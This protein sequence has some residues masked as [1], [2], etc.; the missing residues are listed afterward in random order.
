M[1]CGKCGRKNVEEAT[2]CI[3]C[4]TRL[5]QFMPGGESKTV[6]RTEEPTAT[7][8]AYDDLFEKPAQAPASVAVPLTET[9]AQQALRRHAGS[10]LMTIVG[11][12]T[13]IMTVLSFFSAIASVRVWLPDFFGYSSATPAFFTVG[14]VFGLL[15]GMAPAILV[16]LAIWMLRSAARGGSTPMSTTGFLILRVI[17]TVT[18]ICSIVLTCLFGFVMMISTIVAIAEGEGDAL[19]P[20]FLVTLLLC[21][22]MIFVILFFKKLAGTMASLARVAESGEAT[23]R[24]ISTYVTV[25]FW[26]LSIGQL[27]LGLI[28]LASAA[29]ALNILVTLFSGSA[30]A[31]TYITYAILLSRTKRG[32]QEAIAIPEAQNASPY[33]GAADVSLESGAAASLYRTKWNGDEL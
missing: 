3:G 28:L 2:F 5:F 25:L 14:F 17:G 7:A 24:E 9:P 31:M 21:G 18:Y 6:M 15:G 1:Y 26:I 23:G 11:I 16:I 33:L 19:L 10:G 12:F 32:L 4:G 22:A 8:G 20:I 27:L 29:T 30:T 13:I